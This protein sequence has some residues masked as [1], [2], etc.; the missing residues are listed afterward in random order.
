MD[1][2]RYQQ[3]LADDLVIKCKDELDYQ[4]RTLDESLSIGVYFMSAGLEAS[5]GADSN[6]RILLTIYPGVNSALSTCQK[7]DDSVLFLVNSDSPSKAYTYKLTISIPHELA[8]VQIHDMP[9]EGKEL[10]SEFE[11]AGISKTILPSHK[12]F[13]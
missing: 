8:I 2:E 3:L 13:R 5:N 11:I 9:N 12:T 4:C 10:I 7:V 1:F 6:G